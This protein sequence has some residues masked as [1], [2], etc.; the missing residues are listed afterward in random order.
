MQTPSVCGNVDVVISMERKDMS[1][2]SRTPARNGC[3]PFS[4]GIMEL[5]DDPDDLFD[6]RFDCEI[7]T[8]EAMSD[9]EDVPVKTLLDSPLTF[10]QRVIAA[11]ERFRDYENSASKEMDDF[12]KLII[13]TPQSMTRSTSSSGISS[14][15]PD[16]VV[17]LDLA[18]S[19]PSS[20]HSEYNL[21]RQN[22]LLRRKP[23]ELGSGALAEI[24]RRAQ[25][26]EREM[27][28]AGRELMRKIKE[29]RSSPSTP[30]LEGEKSVVGDDGTVASPTIPS[31]L[32]FGSSPEMPIAAPKQSFIPPPSKIPSPPKSA[33]KSS[34][35]GVAHVN[36]APFPTVLNPSPSIPANHITNAETSAESSVATEKSQIEPE[37]VGKSLMGVPRTGSISSDAGK[38]GK[39]VPLVKKLSLPNV[40]VGK[41][42]KS[43]ESLPKMAKPAEVPAKIAKLPENPLNWPARSAVCSRSLRMPKLPAENIVKGVA[44]MSFRDSAQKGTYNTKKTE[45]TAAEP[46][47]AV[48]DKKIPGRFTLTPALAESVARLSTPK[49]PSPKTSPEEKPVSPLDFGSLLRAKTPSP[50]K[51]ENS[52]TKRRL[53]FMPSTA[54]GGAGRR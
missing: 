12:L 43:M 29:R 51:K 52:A 37:V 14:R 2:L 33:L 17:L 22:S 54:T 45:K 30:C 19:S 34:P 26:Q 7:R 11:R 35:K 41:I 3:S 32:V 6:E 13:P 10:K 49:K 1:L 9:S 28:E 24:A 44:R 20:A 31:R 46:L 16:S 25:A 47:K 27:L 40:A 23:E 4:G 21:N 39:I 36:F 5:R 48:H 50:P 15:S 53:S 38:S 8:P 18:S 42:A